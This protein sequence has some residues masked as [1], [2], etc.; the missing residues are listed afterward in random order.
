MERLSVQLLALL[1]AFVAGVLLAEALGAASLGVA[2]GV[3]QIA[4]SLALGWV[5]L[6]AP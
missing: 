3:G 1:G 2:F 6:R 4:F 5:L